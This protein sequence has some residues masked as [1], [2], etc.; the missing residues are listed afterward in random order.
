[1]LCATAA[2]AAQTAGQDAAENGHERAAERHEAER[3]WIP[4]GVTML[5]EQAARRT[6]F[7][8]EHE[9]LALATRF[10][11]QSAEL[12]RVVNGVNG[13]TVE[14]F[15]FPAGVPV[16]PEV[17][18]GIG[19]EYQD[20]GWMHLVKKHRNERGETSDL[21]VR[22]DGMMIRDI[23]VL[24]VRPGHVDFVAVSGTISPVDLMHLSGHF[25]IPK[26]DSGVGVPLPR[27]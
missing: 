17:L 14:S 22:L 7:R 21:W 19:R 23:D 2:G 25:G 15:G 9:V 3:E 10:T 8:L 12:G 18:A 27:P 5:S 13:V 6:H 20:G 4:Q 24:L 26:M 16:N 1:M 11:G